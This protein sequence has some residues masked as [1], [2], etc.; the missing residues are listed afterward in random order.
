M[1]CFNG[2]TPLQAWK[3]WSRKP[4]AHGR[5]SFNGATPLQAWKGIPENWDTLIP[6]TLQWGHAFAGVESSHV[7][8]CI[9]V[10]YGASMGP[11]L[12][13]R[14]KVIM[15]ADLQGRCRSFNGA[16]PLQA[17]KEGPGN[18][19]EAGRIWLQ[20]GHAFAG[21]E[22]RTRESYKPGGSGFNGATPLQAWKVGHNLRICRRRDASMGPRLCRRGKTWSTGPA[23]RSSLSF[24][25]ATPL[26]A[27]KARVM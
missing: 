16:T 14:G 2:A 7:R 20:W 3:A 13:R 11:R 27:W 24:N 5:R 25:G 10:R 17:W 6:A 22:R 9:A 19:R 12:C 18:R 23:R 4:Y 8:P 15:P 26:Q 1:C 21:V